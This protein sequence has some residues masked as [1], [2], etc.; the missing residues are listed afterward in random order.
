MAEHWALSVVQPAGD[1][2]RAGRKT[3]EV[4]QWQPEGVP[5]RDLVIVQNG[6]RLS[7]AGVQE[8]AEG[9][10]VALVD[11]VGVEPWGRQMLDAACATA[12][13]PGWLA[14]R[15]ERVRPLPRGLRVPARLR[16]YRVVL[17]QL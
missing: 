13:E 12:W 3:L 6:V 15:L 17:P 7:S 10:A 2:I 9:E 14:W 5:V 16:L 4:R 1:L 11:V 8:D